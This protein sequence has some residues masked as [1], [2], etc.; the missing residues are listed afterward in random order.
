MHFP[1]DP[2][3]I[4]IESPPVL[5]KREID[6]YRNRRMAD[7]FYSRSLIGPFF[8]LVSILITIGLSD[9]YQGQ[10]WML[11]LPIALFTIIGVLRYAHKPPQPGAEPDEYRVWNRHQ[12]YLVHAGAISWSSIVALTCA[13]ELRANNA[14]IITMITNVAFSTAV[15]HSFAMH[16]RQARW[17]MVAFV[18]PPTLVYLFYAVELRS[19]GVTVCIYFL[20]LI[21]N[22]Q[23][24][25]RE[26]KTQIETEI[27]LIQSKAEV[28]Q[29][30]LTDALTG[31]PNR[32]SYESTWNHIWRISA[33]KTEVLAL[34]MI[35]LDHFKRINDQYG[36]IGGDLCLQHFSTIL[37]QHLRR[38]SDVIARI[39]GEEFVI[40]LPGATTELAYTMAE[41]LREDLSDTPC[42]IDSFQ[43]T[44]TA[45]FG[46][47]VVDWSVDRTPNDTFHRVDLAC[48][49]AKTEGRNKVVR[50]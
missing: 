33:R 45:S 17:C 20:Y 16:P 26:Y 25:A 11:A 35:D 4:S 19:I 9:F 48:Y 7:D 5:M 46:V 40:I 10:L 50:A 2:R 12:W 13:I 32:R 15:S 47:G 37:R 22:V 27:S 42:Q 1:T 8:Y 38:E 29:L 31:L 14:V 18:L 28:A 49:Q 21:M 23:R 3:L 39:G 43:V 41:N 34:I 24:N 44:L 6:A 30:S 36:H